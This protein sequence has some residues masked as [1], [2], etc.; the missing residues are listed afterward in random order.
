MQ[1]WKSYIAADVIKTK[2]S[3]FRNIDFLFRVIYEMGYH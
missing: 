3:S 2:K 1:T